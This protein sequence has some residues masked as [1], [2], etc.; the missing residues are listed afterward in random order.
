MT[1]HQ[2]QLT[3]SIPSLLL[4][5]CSISAIWE[6]SGCSLNALWVL[7]NWIWAQKMKIESFWQV[8]NERRWW[9][10]D[11]EGGDFR[12]NEQTLAFLELLSEPKTTDTGYSCSHFLIIPCADGLMDLPPMMATAVPLTRILGFATIELSD[13]WNIVM[14]LIDLIDYSSKL[15]NP[16][17]TSCCNLLPGWWCVIFLAIRPGIL[18]GCKMMNKTWDS[19]HI[20]CRMTGASAG[21]AMGLAEVN[22]DNKTKNFRLRLSYERWA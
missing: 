21:T 14:S 10:P 9:F 6:L 1:N 13:E 20:E 19:L 2:L 15:S 7:L 12:T 16:V 8:R 22:I 11:A 3:L 18:S 5:L 4:Y 17:I